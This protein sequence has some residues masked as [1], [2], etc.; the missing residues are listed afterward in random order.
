MRWLTR[1]PDA[2]FVYAPADEVLPTAR[3]VG[4]AETGTGTA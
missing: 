3:E 1:D 4:S 2:E